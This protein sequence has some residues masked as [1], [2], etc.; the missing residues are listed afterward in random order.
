M[1]RAETKS[2]LDLAGSL[3]SPNGAHVQVEDMNAWKAE[4]GESGRVL[5]ELVESAE[6]L[7]AYG[8]VSKTDMARMKALCEEPPGDVSAEDE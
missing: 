7:S 1:T 4:G 3:K 8:V 6:D 5:R 2:V